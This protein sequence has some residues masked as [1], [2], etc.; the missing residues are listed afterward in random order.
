MVVE[1]VY[2]D[3]S[4]LQVLVGDA[5]SGTPFPQLENDCVITNVDYPIQGGRDRSRI[6]CTVPKG[7]GG[8]QRVVV[9]REGILRSLAS[10]KLAIAYVKPTLV[11]LVP[12][13]EGT[14]FQLSSE[15]SSASA[16]T[17]RY[18]IET[19]G[20]MIVARGSNFGGDND[21]AIV[22]MDGVP[23]TTISRSVDNGEL[24]FIAPCGSGLNPRA[25]WISVSGQASCHIT[26][27]SLTFSTNQSTAGTCMEHSIAYQK[28]VVDGIVC[29]AA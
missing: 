23:L 16:A 12:A 21:S 15:S 20:Q 1:N 24:S 4:K 27:D 29:P 22:Y 18:L 14:D 3:A 13:E 19:R 8:E 7:Q 10:A 28:P 25:L 26:S 5:E 6:S 2:G 17:S 11:K 9:V